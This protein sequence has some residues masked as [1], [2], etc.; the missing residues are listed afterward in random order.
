MA[1]KSPP[2]HCSYTRL[3]IV[4]LHHIEVYDQLQQAK[5]RWWNPKSS[6]AT[7]KKIDHKV[8]K[9]IGCNEKGGNQSPL[10]SS[11]QKSLQKTTLTNKAKQKTKNKNN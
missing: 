8:R 3:P 4:M 5:I 1:R 9:K 7:E 6:S 11:L 10:P 2:T